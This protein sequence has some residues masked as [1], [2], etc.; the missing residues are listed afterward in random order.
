MVQL[1]PVTGK[2]RSE[3]TDDMRQS[4]SALDSNDNLKAHAG[5]MMHHGGTSKDLLKAS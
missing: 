5:K 2:K 3:L 4:F 1:E